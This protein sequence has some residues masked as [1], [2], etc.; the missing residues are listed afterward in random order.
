MP[1][2]LNHPHIEQTQP[3]E[4]CG[5]PFCDGC[6]VE[7]TGRKLCYE[8]KAQAVAGVVRRP[9]MHHLAI[10]SLLIPAIGYLMCLTPITGPIGLVM[11]RRV[12]NEI[13]QEPHLSGRSVALAAMVTAGGT[14]AAFLV[15]I[16][17]LAVFWTT[18]R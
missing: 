16:L 6:L 2:C 11:G 17:A 1:V 10:L 8:C 5:R 15:A 12:L 7:I 13:A 18:A 4:Q 3:C 14:L 9:Q